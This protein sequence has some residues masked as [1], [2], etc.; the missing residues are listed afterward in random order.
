MLGLSLSVP[1]E[2]WKTERELELPPKLLVGGKVTPSVAYN[3]A[4]TFQCL[5][6]MEFAF[7]AERHVTHDP[8]LPLTSEL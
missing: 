2:V 8:S 7:D 4:G 3:P 1:P 6:S 5:L